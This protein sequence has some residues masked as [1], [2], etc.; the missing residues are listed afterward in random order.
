[1]LSSRGIDELDEH[2]S[3]QD[4]VHLVRTALDDPEIAPSRV[5]LLVDFAYVLGYATMLLPEWKMSSEGLFPEQIVVDGFSRRAVTL[6]DYG[7]ESCA[8]RYAS[9]VPV[10]PS[11]Y[12]HPSLRNRSLHLASSG[13]YHDI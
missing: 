11:D 1:M 9:G 12:A 10:T 5:R 8:L 3:V 13:D 7:K 6:S 2:L 4:I